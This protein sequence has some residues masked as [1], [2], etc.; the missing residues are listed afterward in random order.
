MTPEEALALLRSNPQEGM[1]QV[2]QEVFKTVYGPR[3]DDTMA[4]TLKDIMQFFEM[5]SAT[6]MKEWRG[7]SAQDK[8]QIKSGIENG[9][10]TY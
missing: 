5:D 8:E 1:R 3:K 10:L 9:S 2:A 7:L 4:V 6:F